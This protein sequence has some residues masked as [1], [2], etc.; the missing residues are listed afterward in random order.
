MLHRTWSF[1][2][3]LA[4]CYPPLGAQHKACHLP[5]MLRK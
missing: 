3:A 1:W 2:L 5:Y 4:T